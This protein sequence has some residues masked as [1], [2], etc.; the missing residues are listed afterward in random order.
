MGQGVDFAGKGSQDVSNKMPASPGWASRGAD[1]PVE[2]VGDGDKDT[3][4]VI[5]NPKPGGGPQG[6]GVDFV[7]NV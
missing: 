5:S 6:S 7:G 2:M 4:G 3:K 1:G